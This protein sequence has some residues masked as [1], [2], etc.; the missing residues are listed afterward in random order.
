MAALS[1]KREKEHTTDYC[2]RN[3]ARIPWPENGI[4]LSEWVLFL[5]ECHWHPARSGRVERICRGP[6]PV[7]LDV[8]RL[9]RED[10]A[11]GLSAQWERSDGC[12]V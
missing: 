8:H 9:A 12:T 4:S 11:Y 6:Q 7:T 2:V 1:F 5:S 3:T 10:H